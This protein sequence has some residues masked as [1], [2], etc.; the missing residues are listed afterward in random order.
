[1]LAILLIAT[2]PLDIIVEDRTDLVELNHLY[3]EAGKHVFDQV[4]WW[5]WRDGY[6]EVIDWRLVKCSRILP[7]RDYQRGGYTQQW[8]DGCLLRRVRS[9]A[10]RE[11]WTQYDVE[12]VERE[13]VPQERRRMLRE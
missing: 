3:D 12:L 8:T 9:Q 5:E 13:V 7:K 10:Y 4:I 2:I 6:Y 1:M 11:T